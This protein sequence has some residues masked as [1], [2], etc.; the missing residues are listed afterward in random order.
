MHRCITSERR[1]EAKSKLWPWLSTLECWE[2]V[3]LICLYSL[4]HKI[5]HLSGI[6]CNTLIRLFSDG[7]RRTAWY[8]AFRAQCANHKSILQYKNNDCINN[9]VGAPC[10]NE[11]VG[12]L[13]LCERSCESNVDK[14]VKGH[15]VIYATFIV[16]RVRSCFSNAH[17]LYAFI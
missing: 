16:E 1:F 15:A 4:S 5:C 2:N 3:A 8:F 9:S 12:L 14:Q 7:Q 6:L 17:C 13:S 11:A 10:F